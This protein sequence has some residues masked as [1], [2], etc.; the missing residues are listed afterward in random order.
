V[1]TGIVLETAP[2]ARLVRRILSDPTV[3]IF[4]AEERSN[5]IMGIG[6]LAARD[7]A[8]VL[9]LDSDTLEERMLTELRLEIGALVRMGN[10]ACPRRLVLAIP[11]VEAVLFADRA[12]LEQ[13]LAKKITDE[14]AFEARFRPKAVFYRLLGK[15]NAT[16]RAIAVIDRLS[17]EALRRMAEHPVIQEF[18]DEVRHDSGEPERI[19]RAS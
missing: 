19:R 18:I 16:E 1:N 2:T 17:D 7:L 12:G 9:V 8:G 5:A 13:A 10:A 4:N 14:Q 3:V 11:Q 6:S 15:Q